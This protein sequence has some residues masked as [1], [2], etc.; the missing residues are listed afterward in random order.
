MEWFVVVVFC[1]SVPEPCTHYEMPLTQ[2]VTSE[3]CITE[4]LGVFDE[5]EAFA[6]EA[7]AE[8]WEVMCVVRRAT[9]V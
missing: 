4:A 8:D 5:A 7:K 3:Q 6:V 2:P 1:S 9:P